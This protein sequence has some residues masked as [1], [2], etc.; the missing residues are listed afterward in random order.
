MA[1]W[2]QVINEETGKSEFVPMDE[3]AAA[4]D[5]SRGILVRGNFDAFKSPIDGSV[6][7]TQRQYDDHMRKHGV[8]PAAE[9]TPEFYQRKAEERARLYKGEH[10]SQQKMAR[11]REIYE[12]WNHKERQA[13][14]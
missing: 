7:S 13:N 14:N 1:R 10:T 9:F 12:I 11:K 4:S 3:A 5:K 2:R 8:V 6:I